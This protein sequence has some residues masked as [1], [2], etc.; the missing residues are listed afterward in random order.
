M[1]MV[2]VLLRTLAV[3]PLIAFQDIPPYVSGP[4]IPTYGPKYGS[5]CEW[6]A[7]GLV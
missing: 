7:Q 6:S 3:P 2:L 5:L 4:F 1:I